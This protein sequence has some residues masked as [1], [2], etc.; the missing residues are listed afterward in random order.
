MWA[1]H[2]ADGVISRAAGGSYTL[3]GKDYIETPKYGISQDFQV[4]KGRAQKFTWKVE[5]NKWYHKGKLSN[6]LTIEEVWERVE[7]K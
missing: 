4:I 7:K 5:G 3:Q 2:D 6:G 1:T